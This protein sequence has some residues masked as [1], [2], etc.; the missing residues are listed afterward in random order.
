MT[1]VFN[2]AGIRLLE[3]DEGVRYSV[4]L[5]SRGL[6]TD[7]VGHLIKPG[8]HFPAHMTE[9]QVQDLLKRDLVPFEAAINAHVHVKLTQNQYNSLVL[10]TFN[11]GIGG[12][13]ISETL[14]LLNQGDY[15]GA[16]AAMMHFHSP[17]EIIPRRQKDMNLFL[18]P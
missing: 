16:C 9:Q 3:N 8:E 17:P 2:Y 18:T 12:L 4:Y 7:G 5:D 6:P 13:L 1:Y 10:F 15:K 11:V 14:R